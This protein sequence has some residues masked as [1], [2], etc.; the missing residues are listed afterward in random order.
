MACHTLHYHI[1]AGTGL[2]SDERLGPGTG[3]AARPVNARFDQGTT[4]AGEAFEVD[5]VP[6]LAS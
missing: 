6:S 3:R 2:T 4:I 5:L 1:E